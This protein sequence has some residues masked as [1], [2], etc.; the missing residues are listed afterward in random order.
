MA[1]H[2]IRKIILIGAGNLATNLGIALK[3]SG[4]SIIQVYNRTSETGLQ[5]A[6]TLS[7]EFIDDLRFL[8]RD[9]DLYC[10]A[11]SDTAFVSVAKKIRL[12]EQMVIHCSGTLEIGLLDTCS[13]NYGVI[14]PPQTFTKQHII[15]FDEIPLCV[16]ANNTANLQKLTV[17]A[18]TLSL[19]VL[20]VTFLQRRIIHLSSVMA[21][22]FSNFLY[23]IAEN[24]LKEQNLPM[25]LIIPLIEKTASNA[26]EINIFDHQ[27][28]PAIREDYGVIENHLDLLAG[29]PEYR[30]IYRLMTECIIQQ[31]NKK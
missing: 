12:Q 4:H 24:L 3:N 20:P 22:N 2:P 5:L 11:V 31:K 9:A 19:K 27:T 16:E 15:E 21:G 14:Y 26:R 17:F 23:S 25:D 13:A 29:S 7:S 1:I 28:G 8:S 18:R 6:K 30:E 10:I